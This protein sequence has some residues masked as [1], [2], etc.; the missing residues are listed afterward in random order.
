MLAAVSATSMSW[1]ARASPHLR[2][3]SGLLSRRRVCMGH[4][5]PPSAAVLQPDDRSRQLL[6]TVDTALER[7]VQL[8]KGQL[9]VVSVSGGADSVALLRLLLDL[10]PRWQLRLHVLHFNH[11]LRP[12]AATEEDFVRA[13]AM[14]HELP[15]HVRRLPVGWVEG[16]PGGMQERSR[17]WRR[18]ESTALLAELRV[19]DS[20]D[21]EGA[22]ALAHHGDDQTETVLL[23]AV[24]GVHLSRVHGMRWRH[25]GFVRPLLG[26]RKQQ[27]LQ[28]LDA[29]GQPWMEDASNAEPKYQR[30][31]V[32]LQLVPL[33]AEMAGG[34]GALLARMDAA[35]QQ[36]AELREWLEAAAADHLARDRVWP[37]G[38]SV[39]ALLSQPPPVQD[40]L[41]RALLTRRA[42]EADDD[43]AGGGGGGGG[44][45]QPSYSWLRR[46][47]AQ[48]AGGAGGGAGWT[49][50]L[51][52]D[53]ALRRTGDLLEACAAGPA[54]DSRARGGGAAAG[55]GAGAG[56]A[57]LAWFALHDSGERLD[58]SIAHPA[59]CRLRAS[60][61]ADGDAPPPRDGVLLH[62]VPRGARLLVRSWRE[63]DV[64]QP[65]H[66]QKPL[67]LSHYLRAQK[68]ELSERRL[69]PLVLRL[70]EGDAD[71]DADADAANAGPGLVIAVYP[72]HVGRGFGTATEAAE[73]GPPPLHL[74]LEDWPM[75]PSCV[76]D[77]P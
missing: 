26:V 62:G 10:Q 11:G 7:H 57:S 59:S 23:K 8:A 5:P 67:K 22:V 24:R 69:L 48:I 76:G 6:H 34:E 35:Q 64:H 19:D 25:A 77:E 29:A 55:G 52:G 16:S 17:K 72:E 43:E 27:L 15:I 54:T 12:E 38:L 49:L 74:V 39:S 42:D 33:L 58:V 20:A 21:D 28:Y 18:S 41:L 75:L 73:G 44:G 13:L 9:L 30:N 63:G 32:R 1:L 60:R 37:R 66:A 31:R 47:R 51:D 61:W 36:S 53:L 70:A 40:E 45:R 4:A 56:A 2:P 68:V 3:S 50:H 71:A 46:A 65:A 14:A